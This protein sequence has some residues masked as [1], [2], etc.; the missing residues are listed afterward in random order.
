[1]TSQ[2]KMGIKV[3]SEHKDTIKQIIDDVK[4]D[5]VKSF[6]EYFKNIAEDHIDELKDYYTRLIAMEDKAKE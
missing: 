6:K 4:A 2:V 3:E 5:K 1:M